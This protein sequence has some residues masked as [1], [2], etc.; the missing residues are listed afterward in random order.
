MTTYT[1]LIIDRLMFTTVQRSTLADQIL[2]QLTDAIANG[3]YG[4]GETLPSERELA[5]MFGVSRVAVREA[6]LTLQAQGLIDRS[7][8][9]ASRVAY[10]QPALAPQTEVIRLPAQPSETDVR[11]VK[12]ARMLVEVEMVRLAA[13]SITPLT[14]TALRSALQANRDAISNSSLFLST[15]MALHSLIASLSGN[16]LFIAMSRE[17]LGW[18]ARLR[19]D[20]VHLEGSDMLSHREHTRIVERILA[21]DGDAAA[22]AMV[23]HLSRSHLAYGRLHS[24]QTLPPQPSLATAQPMTN[25]QLG[26]F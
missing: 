23:E 5:T 22:Q 4:A 21:R 20:V 24:L 3:L 2:A 14:A 10:S 15:D 19:T 12:Q 8:G 9:R 6:L 18:L 13:L 7:H 17:M 16:A 25:R 26:G 1:L 11:D